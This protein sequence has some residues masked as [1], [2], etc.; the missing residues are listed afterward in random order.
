[1]ERSVK[2]RKT[3]I[4]FVLSTLLAG[5]GVRG[6]LEYPK[7]SQIIDNSDPLSGHGK[8]KG[9]VSKPHKDFILD[10]LIY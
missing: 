9:S 4:C 7:N 10:S 6:G 5:C 3:L 2:L 8:L 1:M